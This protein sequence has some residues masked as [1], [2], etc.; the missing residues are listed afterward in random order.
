MFKRKVVFI[1]LTALLLCSCAATRYS[2]GVSASTARPM[3]LVEPY[4]E[5]FFLPEKGDFVED[6][7][8]SE[9]SQEL[10]SSIVKL[11]CPGVE[12]VINRG[13][14]F[15]RE[16]SSIANVKIKKLEWT[17][18]APGICE[19]LRKSGYRYGV[20]VYAT[21]FTRDDKGFM[22]SAIGG[23]LLGIATAVLTLGMVSV[24]GVSYK[25]ASNVYI[26]VVDAQTDKVVYYDKS[27]INGEDPVSFNGLK[28]QVKR[29]LKHFK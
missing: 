28:R 23:A 8:N 25:Y 11:N 10:L 24:Y 29:I 2:S 20:L 15:G 22:K 17:K 18:V 7:R 13:D 9:L 21:G 6:S 16:L 27:T 1:A 5:I 19:L 12:S 4:S 26:M 3:A 14:A